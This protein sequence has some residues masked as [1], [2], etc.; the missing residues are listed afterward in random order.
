MLR[1][2]VS[3]ALLVSGALSG[4][5]LGPAMA[6]RVNFQEGR[7]YHLLSKPV[8]TDAPAGQVEVRAFFAYSCGHCFQFEPFLEEW[9][10][11]QTHVH[12]RRTP[13]AFSSAHVPLQHLYYALE[14]MNLVQTLHPQVFRAIFEQRVSLSSEASILAWVRQQGVD[15]E[16]FSRHFRSPAVAELARKA[17]VLQDAYQI[18]GTPALGVAGRFFISGQGPRTLLVADSLI[19]Q[20]RTS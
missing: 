8:P 5:G 3:R 9:A 17:A 11:V 12:L 14:A 19:R 15:A 10:Q 7:D 18:D 20:V 6:Q 1:R 4:L 13:V 2:D 16:Q